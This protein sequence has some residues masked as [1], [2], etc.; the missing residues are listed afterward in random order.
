MT[1]KDRV[2]TRLRWL[3]IILSWPV[4]VVVLL[5]MI[6]GQIPGLIISLA[7]RMINVPGESDVEHVNADR[8]A[9]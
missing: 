7:N 8:P 6:R 4:A 3:G 9:S 5:F 2:E 1:L